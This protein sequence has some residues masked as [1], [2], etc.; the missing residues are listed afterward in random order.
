V[1]LTGSCPAAPVADTEQIPVDGGCVTYRSTIADPTVPS[2]GPKGGLAF[3][4]R[5]DL[6]AAVAADNEQV[7]CGALATPCP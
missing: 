4:P 1:T 3:T 2:F 6:I 5:T 7:L